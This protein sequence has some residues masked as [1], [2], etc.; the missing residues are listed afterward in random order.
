MEIHF[1][2]N[3]HN[4]TELIKLY[5]EA[6]TGYLYSGNDIEIATVKLNSTA[7]NGL[8]LEDKRQVAEVFIE[9][10]EQQGF[11]VYEILENKPK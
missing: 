11:K 8:N 5:V 9:N 4:M 6:D 2:T 1:G 3:D 7:N 10:L